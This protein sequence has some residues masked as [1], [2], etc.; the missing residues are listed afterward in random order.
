VAKADTNW[1]LE[2]GVDASGNVLQTIAHNGAPSGTF[3][4]VADTDVDVEALSVSAV[5][6]L[7]ANVGAD[8][9]G[10]YGT[11]HLNADGSYTYVVND[12]NATV[13]ALDTGESISES[14]TYTASDGNAN[15]AAATLTITIFGSNDAP[16]AKA[17]TNWALEDGVDASGNVLQTIAHNGAPSGTFGDVA[18]TDVD[19]EALSVSAVN[20]SAANVGADVAGT[21]G[22]LHLNADG[23]YTYTLYTQEENASAYAVVQALDTGDTPLTDAFGYTSSDG[24]A[25]ANSTLTI[26]IFGSNDAPVITPAIVSGTVYEDGLPLGDPAD[27]R[28]VT[29]GSFTVSDSDGENISLTQIQF[30]TDGGSTFS[31]VSASGTSASVDTGHGTLTLNSSDGGATWSWAYVLDS[32]VDSNVITSDQFKVTVTDGTASVTSDILANVSIVDDAPQVS[33]SS[34]I[35]ANETDAVL[36][37]N[38][39][40]VYGGDGMG[41]VPTITA[42][43]L[44][45][46]WIATQD[47]ATHITLSNGTAEAS[48]VLNSDGTYAFTILDPIDPTIV[49]VPLNSDTIKPGG[50]TDVPFTIDF[51]QTE[52]DIQFS[53][54]DGSGGFA[55]VNI[56][57]PGIGI[58]NNNMNDGETLRMD[59]LSEGSAVA[60]GTAGVT[61]DKF[62]QGD[63]F[64]FTTFDADGN[65]VDTGTIVGSGGPQ[66]EFTFFV[67][68]STVSDGSA[69]PFSSL[70]ITAQGSASDFVVTTLQIQQSVV[71]D[72]ATFTFNVEGTDADGD[73]TSSLIAVT[74]DGDPSAG[75]TSGAD[76]L[77]G[78]TGNDILV[79]GGG[80]DVISGSDGA[81]QLFGGDGNDNITG[82]IGNDYLLGDA[83]NDTLTGGLGNDSLAGGAGS[84]TFVFSAAAGADV[85]KD[86]TLGSGGD[87]LN[88][89]DVLQGT[90]VQGN[91]DATT[92]GAFLKVETVGSNTVISVDADGAGSGGAV[93]VVTLEGVS[94]VTLQQLLQNHQI[95]T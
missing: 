26:S 6:G 15:S 42:G 80:N 89:H 63:A 57:K 4:D 72:D 24:T 90:G 75:A 35:V 54:P 68:D 11:L 93:A 59:F 78:T 70:Q 29:S 37:G 94:G 23:T 66:T 39:G 65:V 17:D 85:V 40:F 45:A 21:Y 27:P 7:A 87:V 3:G 18:D 48:M 81:D 9:A 19:V 2:D 52:I 95:V 79:G 34:G 32:A 61:V 22:T 13:N 31:T 83:G 8:V 74:V 92:L 50:P 43:T 5:N 51:A 28:L 55:E 47:D 36:T 49:P 86:F 84:D 58:E 76:T 20:G 71:P 73:S 60:V 67:N 30:S 41:P 91:T 69:D 62:G 38:V 16:V 14:F 46:G 77:N 56:S 64:T 44:P 10:T 82:G 88:V 25:S 33:G 53:A 12:A 1:A